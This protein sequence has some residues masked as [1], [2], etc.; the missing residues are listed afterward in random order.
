MFAAVVLNRV[1]QA[2][3]DL[4]RKTREPTVRLAVLAALPTL[5]RQLLRLRRLFFPS[6]LSLAILFITAA[7]QYN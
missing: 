4:S 7:Q 6:L 2:G 1:R 5:S 3:T